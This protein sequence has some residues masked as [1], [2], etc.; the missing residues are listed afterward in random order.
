MVTDIKKVES[1]ELQYILSRGFLLDMIFSSTSLGQVLVCIKR[2]NYS[3]D[4]FRI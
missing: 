4:K 2:S 1:A 3:F